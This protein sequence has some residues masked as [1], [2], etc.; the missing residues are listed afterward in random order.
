MNETQEPQEA[1]SEV[2]I[3]TLVEIAGMR[4]MLCWGPA[5]P[6]WHFADGSTCPAE[7]AAPTKWLDVVPEKSDG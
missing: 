6:R 5:G 7:F 2:G 4:A 3:G 1:P